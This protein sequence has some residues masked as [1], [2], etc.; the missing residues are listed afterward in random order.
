M[1]FTVKVLKMAVG[2]LVLSL[3]LYA[4]SPSPRPAE[5]VLPDIHIV[6]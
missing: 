5:M 4:L 2:M 6:E 1:Q 3:L